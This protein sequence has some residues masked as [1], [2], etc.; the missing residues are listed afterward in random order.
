MNVLG[1]ILAIFSPAFWGADGGSTEVAIERVED[2]RAAQSCVVE[3]HWGLEAVPGVKVELPREK[4]EKIL[5]ALAQAK[6]EG[7]EVRVG[8]ARLLPNVR[9]PF[10]FYYGV[11]CKTPQ[12]RVYRLWMADKLRAPGVEVEHGF[13][14][15]REHER[16]LREAMSYECNKELVHRAIKT[17]G[18]EYMCEKAAE[19]EAIRGATDC[20][21]KRR[22]TPRNGE[23]QFS[24]S[25]EARREI[26]QIL[27]R[28]QL[29]P[30]DKVVQAV[31]GRA[32]PSSCLTLLYG[33]WEVELNLHDICPESVLE[34]SP[35]QTAPY[36]LEDT[37]YI[38][39]LQ[40]VCKPVAAPQLDDFV[41]MG[42]IL[43]PLTPEAGA[44]LHVVLTSHGSGIVQDDVLLLASEGEGVTLRRLWENAYLPQGLREEGE[45]AY[46]AY[47]GDSL[48]FY[49]E[50]QQEKLRLPY[51][52]TNPI[53]M[54]ETAT[55][56]ARLGWMCISEPFWFNNSQ[57]LGMK[58][59][60]ESAEAGNKHALFL[61]I[62]L[63]HESAA[64]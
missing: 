61:L 2:V 50:K 15:P 22:T 14:F 63:Q 4:Q 9:K 6:P 49:N 5:T 21:V 57:P 30:A 31:G 48:I 8:G 60:R 28:L 17:Q 40:L 29:A 16:E 12:H 62:M 23:K 53:P 64:E 39:L 27:S 13:I 10:A 7:S 59:L 19:L 11:Y 43:K 54:E 25:P 41:A 46:Y 51:S 20:Y 52:I 32:Q 34:K 33:G 55:L 44:G 36:V 35:W 42:R 45:L 37:S 26:L 3:Y 1:L 56:K 58:L 47:S 38:R 18:Q 24:P